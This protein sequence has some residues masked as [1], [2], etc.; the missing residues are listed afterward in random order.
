M[1]DMIYKIKN[2]KFKFLFYLVLGFVLLFDLFVAVFD[3]VQ[4][5]ELNKNSVNRFSGFIELNIIAGVLN[6]LAI[7]LIVVYLIISKRK[8]KVHLDDKKSH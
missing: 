5:V 6:V 3:I 8:I 4:V 7:V 1:N 2:N